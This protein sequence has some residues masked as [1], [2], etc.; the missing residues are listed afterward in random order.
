MLAGGRCLTGAGGRAARVVAGAPAPPRQHGA[1]RPLGV[2]RALAQP[3]V[4]AHV[5][6]LQRGERRREVRE[7]HPAHT[8]H[9]LIYVRI[10][11]RKDRIWYMPNS[12][13]P[14][15]LIKT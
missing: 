12:R 1:P 6:Q 2:Q 10:P 15:Q 9:T 7:R 14:I 11:I 13:T 4:R 5:H 8:Q 3:V